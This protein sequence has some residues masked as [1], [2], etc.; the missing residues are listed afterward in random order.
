M[1][2]LGHA[3]EVREG[4]HLPSSTC[5]P[6]LISVRVVVWEANQPQSLGLSCKEKLSHQGNLGGWLNHL[7]R[8]ELHSVG[9]VPSASSEEGLAGE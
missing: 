8:Q 2:D 6:M 4:T 5:H 9:R 1:E 7:G 3:C